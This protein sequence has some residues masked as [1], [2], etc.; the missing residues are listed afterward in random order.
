MNGLSSLILAL[1][2]FISIIITA[3]V[4]VKRSLR[5][6]RYDEKHET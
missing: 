5:D 6:I 4:L 2:V 3:H 1:G